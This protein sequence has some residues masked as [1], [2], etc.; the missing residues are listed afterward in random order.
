MVLAPPD[1]SADFRTFFLPLPGREAD[2]VPTARNGWVFPTL[3]WAVLRPVYLT[4]ST[5]SVPRFV[6]QQGFEPPALRYL[7]K[8]WAE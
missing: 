8:R 6:S 1:C 4:L 7:S 2:F 5:I 3:T